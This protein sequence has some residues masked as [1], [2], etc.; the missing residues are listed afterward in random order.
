MRAQ[1]LQ[2]CWTLCDPMDCS[3]D[4][5]GKN[6]KVGCCALLQGIFPTQGSNPH[7]LC[8]P[9]L[10]GG[11]CIFMDTYIAMKLYDLLRFWG[12]MRIGPMF[13]FYSWKTDLEILRNVLIVFHQ[14]SNRTEDPHSCLFTQPCLELF[15]LFFKISTLQMW[16]KFTSVHQLHP[17]RV[18]AQYAHIQSRIS[19]ILLFLPMYLFISPI[20][21]L[22]YVF[23]V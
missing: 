23:V 9:A 14:G 13:S 4:S 22:L 11:S 5:P 8:L 15:V 10:A 17:C 6:T 21:Y 18:M 7:L 3:R 20:Q 2:L 19:P 12:H 1:S 16:L